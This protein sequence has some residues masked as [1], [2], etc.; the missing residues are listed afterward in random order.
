MT[1]ADAIARPFSPIGR[2]VFRRLQWVEHGYERARASER[3][4]GDSR[5]R[6][7]FVLALFGAGF[8]TLGLGATRAALFSPYGHGGAYSAPAADA[9]AELTDRNGEVMAL[10]VPRYGLYVDPREMAFPGQVQ[11]ALVKALPGLN[12]D[13]L[14]RQ[15]GGDSQQYVIGNLTPKTRDAI[16][17]LGLPGV[18]FAEETGRD[19]P[20]QNFAAHLIGYARDGIGV[21]G[22]ERAFNGPLSADSG[23]GDPVALSIDLRV[24]GALENELNK[25]AADMQPDDAV[26]MV[27]NVRTGEILAMASWPSYDPNKVTGFDRN[28][29]TNRAAGQV[30]EPGSVMKI[31]TL[32]M[33]IDA[34]V[35]TPDTTFDVGHP[36]ELPGQTIHDFDH[37]PS[38]LTLRQVFTYSSNIG[39]A[40]LGLL[41]GPDT[42]ERYFRSFGL[43]NAAPSEL[44][45]STRPFLPP[46]MTQ[47]TV[48]SMA[49]GHSISVTPLQLA[50]GFSAI[51]N[52]GI[53]RPLT[54]RPLAPGQQPA[55]GHRVISE[56]TSATMMA[57]MRDNVLEGTGTQADVVGLRVGGKTGTATKLVNGRYVEGK[58]AANL[59]SFAAIFPTDGPLNADRYLVL[60][61]LDAPK[62]TAADHGVTTAAFTAAPTA[63]RVINRIAPF[64]GVR[65]VITAA[66]LAPKPASTVAT[67]GVNE[68]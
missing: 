27:V 31:L 40:R 2:W 26:G 7:F 53:Y 11:A 17:D 55:A 16:H 59:A 24:Q 34:G 14:A 39:A 65:R 42:M 29:M 4:E 3:A 62:K 58:N 33:G 35:A 49:F 68:Q 8:V 50:T 15:L 44:I 38:V 36:L 30:Y 9:R 12:P 1:V 56:H 46:R 66:D 52:G 43:F 5:L 51:F 54:L 19:Y 32:A 63:G 41:A 57:L 25:A 23:Q 67:A 28:T 48:A 45:E 18:S 10:D 13:K 60:I 47:N 61:M 6:I 21:A 37:E 22:A 64:L 20:L